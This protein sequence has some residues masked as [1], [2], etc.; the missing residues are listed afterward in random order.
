MDGSSLASWDTAEQSVVTWSEVMM[1]PTMVG[2]PCLE[3][4][5]LALPQPQTKQGIQVLLPTTPTNNPP[6]CAF[7]P[8]DQLNTK[9]CPTNIVHICRQRCSECECYF[10][11]GCTSRIICRATGHHLKRSVIS[12]PCP[13]STQNSWQTPLQSCSGVRGSP[14]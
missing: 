1:E 13:P 2:S 6:L 3:R 10:Q 9:V 5:P 4:L 8:L 7:P 14:W 12:R 11:P